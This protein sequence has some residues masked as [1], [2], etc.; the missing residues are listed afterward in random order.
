MS[1]GGGATDWGDVF[2]DELRLSDRYTAN[3]GTAGAETPVG[4]LWHSGPQ[5][6]LRM[7]D[8]VIGSTRCWAAW[9]T[10]EMNMIYIYIQIYIY[11]YICI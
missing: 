11:I 6:N 7:E 9:E 10:I 5:R 1:A 2:G 3:S 4:T 8:S